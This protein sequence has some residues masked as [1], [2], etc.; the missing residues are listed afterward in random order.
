ML[1]RDGMIEYAHYARITAVLWVLFVGSDIVVF[2]QTL[3]YRRTKTRRVS[4]PHPFYVIYILE[5]R[6]TRRVP[7]TVV[8]PNTAKF[9]RAL[10]EIV[11]KYESGGTRSACTL[12]WSLVS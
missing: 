5:W 11:G 7:A 2:L 9:T 10:V 4:D 12:Q 3:T 6:W 1:S 8:L